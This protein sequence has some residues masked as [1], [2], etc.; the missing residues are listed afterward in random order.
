MKLVLITTLLLWATLA[1]A[2]PQKVMGKFNLGIDTFQSIGDK[3]FPNRLIYTYEATGTDILSDVLIE[4]YCWNNKIGTLELF[5][6]NGIL[7]VVKFTLNDTKSECVDY[8][9]VDKELWGIYKQY[10]D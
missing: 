7:Y 1:P 5:F 6:G 9:W 2:Q 3:V 10:W 4:N 8:L